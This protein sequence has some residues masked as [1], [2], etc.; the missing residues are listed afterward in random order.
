ML[1]V[2]TLA[3]FQDADVFLRLADVISNFLDRDGRTMR[4]PFG[5]TVI[6]AFAVAGIRHE[7]LFSKVFEQMDINL[8]HKV[9]LSG[10]VATGVG[11]MVGAL[12]CEP[13]L[14]NGRV[15]LAFWPQ[16]LCRVVPFLSGKNIGLGHVFLK[17]DL[18]VEACVEENL[19][20]WD[21]RLIW[22]TFRQKDQQ[23][24]H[25]EPQCS[26]LYR[27]G[28][29]Q[30]LPSATKPDTARHSATCQNV[31]TKR[32]RIDRLGLLLSVLTSRD[33]ASRLAEN[34]RGAHV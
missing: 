13:H 17:Q 8:I 9:R 29:S 27:S 19:C 32:T 7:G 31:Q 34:A 23:K 30:V 33:R 21:L 16:R 14:P 15:A 6:R 2:L 24:L 11:R 20:P 1:Q 26:R 22:Q 25:G 4:T 12:Y 10:Q 5:T 3:K 28:L 18:K